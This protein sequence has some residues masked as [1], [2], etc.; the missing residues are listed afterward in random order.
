MNSDEF[1]IAKL[2]A[3]TSGALKKVDAAMMERSSKGPVNKIDPRSFI[4]NQGTPVHKNAARRINNP[5]IIQAP[6]ARP[7]GREVIGH[8]PVNIQDLLIPMPEGV[9]MPKDI[10]PTPPPPPPNRDVHTTRGPIPINQTYVPSDLE[11]KIS[12]LEK[13][14]NKID[15]KLNTLLNKIK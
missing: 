15:K 8:E 6:V 9:E 12:K 14:V 13:K 3:V 4:S 1:E 2:A 11:T 7:V 10:F 5:N